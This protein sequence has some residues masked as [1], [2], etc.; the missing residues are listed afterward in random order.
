VKRRD[1]ETRVFI[2]D[3]GHMLVL[4]LKGSG[5]GC[6]V[7]HN[8]DSAGARGSCKMGSTGHQYSV[9]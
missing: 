6:L 9:G 7:E 5:G 2:V 1:R 3:V 8:Y 4:A